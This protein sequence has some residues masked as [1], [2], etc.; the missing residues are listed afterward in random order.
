MLGRAQMS[1]R[2]LAW[3][4]TVSIMAMAAIGAPAFATAHPHDT[5][6]WSFGPVPAL[7]TEAGDGYGDKT[8]AWF[9]R[10][11][12]GFEHSVARD[13]P[14]DRVLDLMR[15]QD[16]VCHPTLFRTEER[17]TF[18]VFS[19]P[20]VMTP[21]V[22]LIAPAESAARAMAP[23]DRGHLR[24]ADI[25]AASTRAV[26]TEGRAYGLGIDRLIEQLDARGRVQRVE[27]QEAAYAHLARGWA[28]FSFGYADAI[29]A[30]YRGALKPFPIATVE[31][32]KLARIA[33][34]NGPMGRAAIAAVDAVIAA[35]GPRPDWLRYYTDTLDDAGRAAFENALERRAPWGPLS[36]G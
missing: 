32:G 18:A 34:S 27:D 25:L 20:V 9:V 4:V 24:I 23:D 26:V 21:S 1:I 22:L 2:G 17:L 14:L 36:D 31:T 33:C 16:G 8:H 11:L 29:D 30:P 10:R 3:R 7:F 6:L 13:L 35:A 15:R 19:A 28:D 12:P 5:I